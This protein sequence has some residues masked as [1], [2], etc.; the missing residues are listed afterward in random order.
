[1]EHDIG[2]PAP[3]AIEFESF[4]AMA[5]ALSALDGAFPGYVAKVVESASGAPGRFKVL[6][7]AYVDLRE[8]RGNTPSLQKRCLELRRDPETLAR[9]LASFPD[10]RAVSVA[11][12]KSLGKLAT[13]LHTVYIGYFVTRHQVF[14]AK[15]VFVTIRQVHEGYKTTGVK[16]TRQ[17]V[18]DHVTL[19]PADIQDTL[20][21]IHAA[22]LGNQWFGHAPRV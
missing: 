2:V 5:H 12:E 14:W 19:L 21:N 4:D 6:G 7:K 1:V 8:L 17:H 18:F 3:Q 15:P 10:A 22:S 16:R 11:T 20:L 9:F 13:W